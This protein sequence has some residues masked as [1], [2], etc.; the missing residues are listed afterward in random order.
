MRSPAPT[1]PPCTIV[2]QRLLSAVS[3]A[4]AWAEDHGFTPEGHL[5]PARRI[6]RYR[7][8][9]RERFL[10]GAELARLG[11]ALE[12]GLTVG[13]PYEVDEIKPTAGRAP[14]PNA[15]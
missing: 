6:T 2:W 11:E 1:S 5:N 4:Y 15:D 12:R 7:E 13:L 8:Q 3:K 10:S 14:R 9:S